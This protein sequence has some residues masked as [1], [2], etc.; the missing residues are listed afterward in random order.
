MPPREIGPLFDEADFDRAVSAL[1]VVLQEYVWQPD[2]NGFEEGWLIENLREQRITRALAAA[3]LDRLIKEG[4][5]WLVSRQVRVNIPVTVSE[6]PERVF[7][8]TKCERVDQ[9]FTT[10]EKWYTF[11]AEHKRARAR[12]SSTAARQGSR[13]TPGTANSPAYLEGDGAVDPEPRYLFQITG[14]ICRIRIGEEVGQFGVC[15]AVRY[16]HQILFSPLRPVPALALGSAERLPR[17][18]LPDKQ[19]FEE[20]LPGAETSPHDGGADDVAWAQYRARC[21]DLTLDLEKARADNDHAKVAVLQREMATLLAELEKQRPHKRKRGPVTP[22]SKAWDAARKA[23]DR[24][25]AKSADR[26]SVV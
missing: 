16:L 26:K 23:L 4:A 17:R 19:R 6:W 24:F 14:G 2:E 1:E 5:S 22:A 12:A 15:K 11:L 9:F 18:S 21:D 3:L 13:E 20:G 10:Q 7:Y 25:Y 8:R